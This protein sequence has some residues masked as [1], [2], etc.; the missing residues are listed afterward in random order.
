M[1]YATLNDA[2][3]M[4]SASEIRKALATLDL[5]ICATEDDGMDAEALIPAFARFSEFAETHGL[6]AR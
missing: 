6:I 3:P 1:S 2:I 4:P 5:V